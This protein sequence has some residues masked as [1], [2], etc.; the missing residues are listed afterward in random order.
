MIENIDNVLLKDMLAEFM[1]ECKYN[2]DESDKSV[3]QDGIRII[4]PVEGQGIDLD[5]IISEE[6]ALTIGTI[7]NGEEQSTINE[8]ITMTLSVILKK[9]G[10]VLSY[11]SEYTFGEPII[12]D[13]RAVD[14]RN[15]YAVTITKDN[16]KG[17]F[18]ISEPHNLAESAA[19][20][21]L[22]AMEGNEVNFPT[23]DEETS[24]EEGK[25]NVVLDIPVEVVVELGKTK[26]T[27]QDVMNLL[28]GSVVELDKLS[29]ESVDVMANGRHFATGE[30][31]VIGDNFGVRLTNIVENIYDNTKRKAA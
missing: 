3:P 21:D 26:M 20:N 25:W 31:V 19:N 1:P 5:L 7:V 13:D 11:F 28:P 4:L 16:V 14:E 6:Q 27:V 15:Y 10:E 17:K 9:I 24:Q 30:V 8:N 23:L 12:T 18:Y 2:I 29:G 22:D